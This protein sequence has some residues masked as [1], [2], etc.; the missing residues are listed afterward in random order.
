[1]APTFNKM[2]SHASRW[3]L[4]IS[5]IVWVVFVLVVSL[6]GWSPPAP[7]SLI[8]A[9]ACLMLGVSFAWVYGEEAHKRLQTED[10]SL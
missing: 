6:G 2:L 5:A 7:Y 4:L 8:L 1:M 9:G 10:E 3:A